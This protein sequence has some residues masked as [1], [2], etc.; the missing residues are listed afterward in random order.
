MT[1]ISDEKIIT[2]I[3]T[4]L[5]DSNWEA[6][7]NKWQLKRF[8]R[9]C[10]EVSRYAKKGDSI[11]DFGCGEGQNSFI[12][13]ALGM[14]VTGLDLAQHTIWKWIQA[15][16]HA[17]NGKKIPFK[18]NSFEHIV[19]FGVLEHV[20]SSKQ[21]FN[22]SKTQ[23][24]RLRILRELYITL[25]PGGLLFIYNFPNKYSPIELV[26]GLLNLP[27]IHRGAEKQ[28]LGQVRQLVK[29]AGFT[30]IKSGRSGVLPASIGFIFP[31]LR[32]KVI[33]RHYKI[34]SQIDTAIDFL[35]GRFFGQSNYVI[36]QKVK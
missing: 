1:R 23:P 7:N 29:D 15:D 14:K 28:S 2:T 16:F 27:A 33:N 35:V 32:D 3:E 34:I 30:V 19:M 21:D 24:E 22:F 25:K 9:Q 31:E 26:N 11:L 8:I 5:G 6:L 20:G 12:L 18:Q 36:A 4:T 10:R 13:N 17:Y